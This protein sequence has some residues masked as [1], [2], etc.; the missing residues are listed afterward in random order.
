MLKTYKYRLSLTKRQIT[1]L[2]KTLEE[3]RWLYNH[4][5]EQR[6]VSWEQ[7]KKGINYYTQAVSIVKLK[8]ERP[9][10]SD[11]YSQ[12]LQNVAVRIDLAFLSLI[13]G[14]LFT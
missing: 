6:K 5:L 7:E 3:C 12:V 11:I 4:F 9:S 8:K 13:G 2:N 14:G 1:I 10:L